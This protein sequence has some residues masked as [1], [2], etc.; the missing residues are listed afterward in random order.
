MSY[1]VHTVNYNYCIQNVH[2][3]Q[4][5]EQYC[6][7][8]AKLNTVINKR[9]CSHLSA[10]DD[11]AREGDAVIWADALQRLADPLDLLQEEFHRCRFRCFASVMNESKFCF[12]SRFY[13]RKSSGNA[14]GLEFLQRRRS[15]RSLQYKYCSFR[16]AVP[17][18]A[19]T[20]HFGNRRTIGSGS[21]RGIVRE[22]LPFGPIWA[23]GEQSASRTSRTARPALLFVDWAATPHISYVQLCESCAEA[24]ATST[25]A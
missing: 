4:F 25:I 3:S 15:R 13:S 8:K 9:E 5:K 24:A 23:V 1:T 17:C 14:I 18:R 19:L 22:H 21:R 2:Y 16:R 20:L 6:V 7:S 12:G 11:N 10:D